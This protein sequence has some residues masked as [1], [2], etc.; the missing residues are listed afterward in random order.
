MKEVNQQILDV[1]LEHFLVFDLKLLVNLI[2]VK[3]LKKY[4]YVIFQQLFFF[5]YNLFQVKQDYVQI[6][7][8]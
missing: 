7:L 3:L 1:L 5:Q 6:E 2:D 4:L 8:L